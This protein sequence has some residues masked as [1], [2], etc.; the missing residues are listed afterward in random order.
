MF[1]TQRITLPAVAATQTFIYKVRGLRQWRVRAIWLKLA[2]GAATE[3]FMMAAVDVPTG[4]ITFWRATLPHEIA[5][6]QIVY[7]SAGI[8]EHPAFNLVDVANNI[9]ASSVTLPD[10]WITEDADIKFTSTGTLAIGAG[11]SMWVE[12]NQTR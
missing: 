1:V 6:N 3:R 9:A 4:N 11:G 12:L 8:N 7:M 5:V 10:F 2:N